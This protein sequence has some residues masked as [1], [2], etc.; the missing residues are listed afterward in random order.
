MRFSLTFALLTLVT[1]QAALAQ[2]GSIFTIPDASQNDSDQ[3]RVRVICTYTGSAS[4]GP[5]FS[6]LQPASAEAQQT[7]NTMLKKVGVRKAIPAY[8]GPVENA[9]AANVEGRGVIIYNPQ[10]MQRLYQQT[11]NNNW[12]AISVLAHELGHHIN[13]DVSEN[14]RA[15]P[16]ELRADFFSGWMLRRLGARLSDAVIAM[17]TI[18]PPVPSTTH[19][20][21]AERVREI[22]K[23]YN[24]K[25]DDPDNPSPSP[26]PGPSV[27]RVPCQHR[28]ACQHRFQCQ[29]RL[30]CNHD[31]P[32]GPLHPY[33]LEHP[34]DQHPYDLEHEYDQVI[35]RD[36]AGPLDKVR[37]PQSSMQ[38]PSPHKGFARSATAG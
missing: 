1:F 4:T 10:F 26:E 22:T 8:E 16:I 30:E 15:H 25:T 24:D 38:P 9:V 34:Y 23:G 31:G 13:R 12:A 18:A 2:E 35:L 33:H 5:S 14:G 32:D 3:A 20:A 28:H 7:I 37:M 29:H 21:K 36:Q 27:Q 11:N 6:D 19:P 17:Q